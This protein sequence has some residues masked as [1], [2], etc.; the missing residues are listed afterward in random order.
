VEL[1]RSASDVVRTAADLPAA[2]SAV[3]D[4]PSRRSAD[5]RRVAAGIFHEPGRATGKATGLICELL[6]LPAAPALAPGAAIA[7]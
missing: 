7:C 6:E 2:I 4:R 1:L 3:L 5:R